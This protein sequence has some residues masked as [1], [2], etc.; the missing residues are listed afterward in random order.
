MSSE[1]KRENPRQ[2][3]ISGLAINMHWGI[4]LIANLT[5]STL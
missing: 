4:N 2:G 5:A 3:K 1:L